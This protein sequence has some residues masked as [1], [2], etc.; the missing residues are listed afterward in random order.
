MVRIG[1]VGYGYW[2]PKVV[3]N[4]N[5]TDGAR[6]TAVSDLNS[7]ARKRAQRAY[8]FIRT[9]SDYRDIVRSPDIDAV[10]VITP[11]ATHFEIAKSALENGKHVFVEKP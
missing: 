9:C 4:I 2:G 8:P 1:V 11:V 10:A 7:D 3:R 6:V 5:D